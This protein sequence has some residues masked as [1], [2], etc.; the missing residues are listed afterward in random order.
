[1]PTA[2][3]LLGEQVARDLLTSLRAAAPSRQFGSLE[4]A[5]SQLSDLALRQR[6]DLLVDALLSDVPGSYAE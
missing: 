5:C 4:P 6:V 1:V 2:D 3:E